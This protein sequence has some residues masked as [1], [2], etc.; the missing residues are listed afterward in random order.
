[1]R[2]S[3]L[4]R[5][6]VLLLPMLA[7]GATLPKPAEAEVAILRVFEPGSDLEDRLPTL[8]KEIDAIYG[9]LVLTNGRLTAVIANPIEGRDAN[10][11]VRD[12][13]GCLV[14]LVAA[15]DDSL[16]GSQDELAV[17]RPGKTKGGYRGWAVRSLAEAD[18]ADGVDDWTDADEVTGRWANTTGLSVRVGPF[19]GPHA[20]YTLRA[21]SPVLEITTTA[22]P[23]DELRVDKSS[24]DFAQSPAGKADWA[25]TESPYWGGAYGLRSQV[26]GVT[27]Q[28]D[29]TRQKRG[30]LVRHA[31][32]DAVRL[33]AAGRSRIDL[34]RRF[35]PDRPQSLVLIDGRAQ[36][37]LGHSEPFSGRA[38]G[39][40]GIVAMPQPDWMLTVAQPSEHGVKE[41]AKVRVRGVAELKLPLGPL[42]FSA[43]TLGSVAIDPVRLFNTADRTPQI[44]L[45]PNTRTNADTGRPAGVTAVRLIT[46]DE[47]RNPI[48]A[49][50]AFDRLDG[51]DPN[52]GP[53]SG[54]EAVRE[55]QYLSGPPRIILLPQG[56]YRVLASRGPEYDLVE[57]ELTV[58]PTAPGLDL[59][60]TLKRAYD[61]PGWLSAD[62]HSHSTPSGDNTSHQRGRVLNL[63]CEDI[64]FAPCTEHQRV[65]TYQTHIDTL[66]LRS[67]LA[68]CTGM[69]LTG[70]DL[71]INHQNVFPLLHKRFTQN[72]GGPRIAD[73]PDVQVER[74]ALWDE[75]SEKLIQQNHPTLARLLADRDNDGKPDDGF[76]RAVGLLDAVE[77]HPIELALDLFPDIPE[78]REGLRKEWT[79]GR[80]PGWLKLNQ[81]RPLTGVINTD[82]HWNHHGSGWARNWIAVDDD[83][84]RTV[85]TLDVVRATEAGRVVMSNGPMLTMTAAAGSS[86][87][88]SQAGIGDTLAVPADG[89]VSVTIE[90]RCANWVDVDR[91]GLLVGPEMHTVFERS[92]GDG[93]DVER[94]LRFRKTLPVRIDGPTTLVAVC[95]HG[96]ET[97]GPAV[98]EEM[99]EQRP[100][101]LTNPIFVRPADAAD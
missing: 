30:L 4:L 42:R 40:A 79:V 27:Q 31:S 55:V 10:L 65:D 73:D 74:L 71:P 50:V 18:G 57:Q 39:L 81:A 24:D 47:D 29:I 23:T 83:D 100:A 17:Y 87:G 66:G 96:T 8:G 98:G 35:D 48:P 20:T 82:A 32:D 37:L 12:V 93:F 85:R 76:A 75:R 46:V 99:S 28:V 21:D 5:F 16:T 49:K 52:F 34:A 7:A 91:V 101:A 51:P 2:P 88:D 95:G 64:D 33:L 78:P 3:A 90:V 69:E 19:E 59:T 61:T 54:V 44:A 25:W 63:V 26:D 67:F 77:I 84:P 22:G 62:F 11:T 14:D 38:S 86:N 70:R 43:E 15:D 1:M 68:S 80:I 13:G 56:R 58:P 9:D 94:P 45:T 6:P 53:V 97:L 89:E 41:L 36:T 92:G 72:G 60:F